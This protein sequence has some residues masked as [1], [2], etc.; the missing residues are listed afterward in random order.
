MMASF[1]SAAR[2]A[3]ASIT[4]MECRSAKVISVVRGGIG[5]C[6]SSATVRS[7]PQ[8]TRTLQIAENASAMA[9]D[10][11]NLTNTMYGA[12]SGYP[13]ASSFRIAPQMMSVCAKGFPGSRTMFALPASSPAAKL[14]AKFTGTLEGVE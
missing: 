14:N 5:D 12:I 1:A 11:G 7:P 10:G 13:S 8:I 9:F 2:Y 4:A 6:R 3:S